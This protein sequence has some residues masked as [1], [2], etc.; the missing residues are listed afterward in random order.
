M[1][2]K[3][4]IKKNIK[5]FCACFLVCFLFNFMLMIFGPAEIYFVNVAEF[6]F[7]YGEFVW[8]LSGIALACSGIISLI[9]TFLPSTARKFACSFIGGLSV[10][11]YVQVMFI[12]K[13]LDLL[14]MNPDG[15]QAN[16]GQALINGIIWIIIPLL[17]FL[18]SIWKEKLW[19]NAILFG[20]IFLISIQ[21]IAWISLMLSAEDTAYKYEEGEWYLSG[22]NQFMVSADQNIIVLVLDYFSNQYIEPTL[23]KYPDLLDCMNDFT[24]YNN[25]DCTYFG[26]YPSLAHILSGSKPDPTIPINDWFINIWKD[27]RAQGFYQALHDQN[28]ISNIYTPDS[29]MICGTN[30]VE[31]LQGIFSNI[32]NESQDFNVNYSLL[33][34]TMLK[35]SGYRM[36][37]YMLKPYL[38]T[39][40]S[41][42]SEIIMPKSHGVS[43]ENHRY[44]KHLLEEGLKTDSQS[45]YYI[46]QHLSGTHVYQTTDSGQYSEKSSLEETAKGCMVIVNEYLNQLK[47]LGVYDNA[48][49]IVTSDHG[50]PRD[51]QIIF[52]MKKAHETHEKLIIS[53]APIALTEFQATIAQAAGLDYTPYGPAI[54]DISPNDPRERTVWVRLYVDSLPSVPKYSGEGESVSNAYCGFTYTGDIT[55]LLE[56]YDSGPD[57]IIPETDGFF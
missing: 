42:Y 37:P 28:Y 36:F 46:F 52:F 41:E 38:Y 19:K 50:G 6:K 16:R 20:S 55:N 14:G 13:D 45:N 24:Y 3:L 22:E 7:V 48:T 57:I 30:S 56:K 18:F 1:I 2:K 11:G 27:E 33:A 32:T 5:N 51:S 39:N 31:I 49:I 23:E 12:N 43:H 40:V 35:M 54:S 26:T 21:S 29:N 8:I 15:Y 25:T 4:S 53:D 47:E 34:K 10:A 44:Y 9:I 17:I